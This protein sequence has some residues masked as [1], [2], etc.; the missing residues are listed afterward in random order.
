M[1]DELLMIFSKP[2][3]TSNNSLNF[4]FLKSKNFS[5]ESITKDSTNK[6]R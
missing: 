4:S 3:K 5:D 1:S 2:Q 6:D